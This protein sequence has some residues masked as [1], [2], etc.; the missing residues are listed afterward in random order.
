VQANKAAIKA[1]IVNRIADLA[2]TIGVLATFYTFQSLE[3]STVFGLAPYLTE[4]T[5][6]FG[7]LPVAPLTLI[8]VLLFLG[9]MGKSAQI[10]LHT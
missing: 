3:F 7:N 4:S 10:G 9:A 8:T 1:M 2:L 6:V 5:L